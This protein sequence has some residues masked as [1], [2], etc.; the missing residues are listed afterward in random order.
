[1]QSNLEVT[2]EGTGLPLRILF[3]GCLLLEEMQTIDLKVSDSE[4]RQYCHR[5]RPWRSVG[6]GSIATAAAWVSAG[7]LVDQG[8]VAS[9]C[10]CAGMMKYV[11]QCHGPVSAEREEEVG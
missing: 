3:S 8:K 11:D 9:C 4:A 6:D 7:C 5:D 2:L 10:G 1:M